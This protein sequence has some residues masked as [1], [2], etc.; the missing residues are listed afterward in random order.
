MADSYKYSALPTYYAP[1]DGKIELYR[2]YIENLPLID[3]P[4]VFGLHSNANIAY[5]TQESNRVIATVLSI[6]PRV[7]SSGDGLTP[8]QLVLE[9]ASEFREALPALLDQA[10]AQKDLFVYNTQGLLPSLSTVLEQEMIKFNRLLKAMEKSLQDIDD[11]ING[12]IVMD[13]TLDKMYLS[14]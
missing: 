9:K 7:A 10:E 3:P 13:E 1:T 6:Q 4:E 12:F 11:A 2:E 8:D 5:M 14:I